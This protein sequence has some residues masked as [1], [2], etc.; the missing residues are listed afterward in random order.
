MAGRHGKS[1]SRSSSGSR[2]KSRAGSGRGS[3][4]KRSSPARARS[5]PTGAAAYAREAVA[6]WGKAVRYAAGALRKTD[7]PSLK[8]RLNPGRTGKG[9]RLGAGADRL[10]SKMGPPG[11]LAAKLGAGRRMV[12]RLRGGSPANDGAH[13]EDGWDDGLPIPVQQAMEVA[14]PARVAYE[15]CLRFADYPEFIDRV[16]DV[17]EIGDDAVAV[18]ATVRGVARRMRIE[19]VDARPGRRIDWEAGGDLPHSGVISFHELAPSLTHIELSLDLEP[20]GLAQ[21]IARAAHL[22][23]RAVRA[24]M[25]RFKAYAELWQEDE[26]EEEEPEDE[27]R[28]DEEEHEDEDEDEPEQ[29]QEQEEE[30]E[31]AAAG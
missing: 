13:G 23:D 18:H 8:D 2:S 19:I 1:G 29:E 30:P 5:A 22:T 25:Q 14:V 27:E 24:D 28:E 15:L 11:S 7:G 31:P 12:E 17:E 6:E 3:G 4:G 21:R 26:T 16:Q 9:G 10:L 20:H